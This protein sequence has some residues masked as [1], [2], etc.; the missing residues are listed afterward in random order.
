MNSKWGWKQTVWF[1]VV[2][3]FATGTLVAAGLH[4]A[5]PPQGPASTVTPSS[6]R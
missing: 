2:F 3:M 1:A 4:E 5:L 6:L